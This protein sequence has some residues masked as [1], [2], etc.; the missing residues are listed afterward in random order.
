MQ[1]G[2]VGLV[3]DGAQDRAFGTARA[4]Q[5]GQRLVGVGR[6]HD[7]VEAFFGAVGEHAHTAM[8][9][10]RIADDAANRRV[11]AFV[12]DAGNDF[13][14]VVPGAAGHRPPL[15]P[16]GHLD[17]A[18]VVAEA[19]HGG[20]RELQ[21]LVGRAGPDA[22]QHGQEIPVAK[23]GRKSALAQEL[24]ERLHHGGFRAAFGQRRGGPVETHDVAKHAPEPPVQEIA[25][26]GEHC[27]QAG[28]AP[29]QGAT[30][31]AAGDLDRK[32]HV[33]AGCGHAQIRKQLDQVGVG[34][35]IEDQKAGVDTVGHRALRRGQSDV[36]RVGMAAKIAAGLEQGE[37]GLSLQGVRD[38]QSGNAGADD[39]DLGA[40]WRTHLIARK[41]KMLRSAPMRTR[42]GGR[43]RRTAPGLQ[44]DRERPEVFATK[45]GVC[46]RYACAPVPTE[47]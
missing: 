47:V 16:V 14:N 41:T 38:R 13:F 20:H 45:N 37:V 34:A 25:A 3:V 26:L 32:R 27:V 29:F 30:V 21:H 17:Q 35:F 39:G 42:E 33:R 5:Q 1:H 6:Q 43:R 44:P 22:T 19:D 9:R 31:A 46:R 40:G 12:G 23:L 8:G 4:L 2:A 11:Q 15:R 24:A 36:D 28:A 7:L 18:V 10:E